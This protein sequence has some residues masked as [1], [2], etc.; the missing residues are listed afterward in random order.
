MMNHSVY[1][2]WE[3]AK[4]PQTKAAL[5]KRMIGNWAKFTPPVGV[6]RLIGVIK[7]V[8]DLDIDEKTRYYFFVDH[9]PQSER[10]LQPLTVHR[11]RWVDGGIV[12][13]MFNGA[14]WVD[15][16]YLI[17]A[18][19]LGGDNDYV[20]TTEEQALQF[21]RS[22]GKGG[23]GSGNFGHEG[24]PGEIGGSAPSDGSDTN[25]A[26]ASYRPAT[27]A[28]QKMADDKEKHLATLITV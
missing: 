19:G 11:W 17:A 26:R 13:E 4:N 18:T 7:R 27:K 3:I 2:R 6:E 5:H 10:Y 15:N 24:R 1:R 8:E 22:H 21:I 23:P 28:A 20:E 12:T 16:P 9:D 25:E 14:E